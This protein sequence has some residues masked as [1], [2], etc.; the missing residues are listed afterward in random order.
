[1]PAIFRLRAAV[2]LLSVA[3]WV[4]ADLAPVHAAGNRMSV[5]HASVVVYGS[6]PAAVMAAVAAG[7]AGMRTVLITRRP[8]VGGVFTLGELNQLDMNYGPSGQLLT[9]GLFL[10]WWKLV[11][12]RYAFGLNDASTAFRTMLSQAHVQVFR[13]QRILRVVRW[14]H[15]FFLHAIVVAGAHDHVREFTARRFIDGSGNASLAADSGVAFTVGRS[16][17]GE[18]PVDQAVTEVFSL[19][20]V[21]WPQVVAYVRSAASPGGGA[22]GNDAWG[23]GPLDRQFHT[24]EPMVRFRGMNL[25]RRSN[26]QVL[27]NAVWIFGVNPLDAGSVRR[28][29]GEARVD[30]PRIVRFLRARAPG[31]AHARL[32]GYAPQLYV[33]ESRHMLGERILTISDL[34]THR[35]FWDRVVL[36]SYPVDMQAA[37]PDQRGSALFDP[38]IYSIPFRSL[39]PRQVDNLLVVGRSAAYTSTAAGSARVEAIGMD[40][41]Q[42]AGDAAALSLHVDRDFWQ[43]SRSQPLIARLQREL[44]REGAYLPDTRLRQPLAASWVFGDLTV[45]LNHLVVAY[46]YHGRFHLERPISEAAFVHMV[47]RLATFLPASAGA[48]LSHLVT[49]APLSSLTP[50]AAT[51]IALRAAG[52]ADPVHPFRQAERDHLLGA[53]TLAHLRA[54]PKLTGA[55]AVALT[56]D[57]AHFLRALPR[58][59]AGRR[60]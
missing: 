49:G 14:A 13:R 2:L 8:R 24:L 51:Q 27:V 21:D 18:G 4:G 19:S 57:L 6:D 54:T 46:G 55:D 1:M 48:R 10:T 58:G 3:V 7:E 44:T 28:A 15:G 30:I 32:V 17:M 56:A 50:A 36:A 40:E 22:Q 23:Y 12:E 43:L 33:R 11:G 45:L 9:Q 47:H 20:G 53:A 42:A 34:L 35:M 37:F 25:G 38:R 16:D 52:L 5:I 29:H 60:R 31:F 26:G 59:P 41:G 39:V